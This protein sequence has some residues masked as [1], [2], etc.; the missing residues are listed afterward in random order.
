MEFIRVPYLLRV[1]DE[2]EIYKET[3]EKLKNSKEVL[4]HTLEILALWAVMT[5]L[6]KPL[7]KG[8]SPSLAKILDSLTPLE[9]A[10]LYENVEVPE[11]LSDEERREL[12]GHAETLVTEHQSLP[13]YEGLMG[14]SAR[15]LKVLLQLASTESSFPT[16]GPPALFQELSELI[17]KPQDYEYLR[18]EPNQGYHNYESMIEWARVAWLDH[19]ESEMLSCLNFDRETQIQEFLARYLTHVTHDVRKEKVR[20]RHTGKVEDP[21]H[22]LMSD[23]ESSIGISA[24]SL[25]DFRK[26]L[27]TRL[28]AWSIENPE[29]DPQKA[30]PYSVIFPDLLSKVRSRFRTEDESKIRALGAAILDVRAFDSALATSDQSTLPE[31]LRYA[32]TAYQGLQEKFGYGPLGAKESLTALVRARYS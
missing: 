3:L 13:F 8:K 14:A 1:S 23:F 30:L 7:F 2:K 10:L 16:L 20:N 4:P 15:E 32:I 29:R 24:E 22:T 31:G 18:I 9:K 19:V 6:K 28:G 11:R 17:Q 26:N 5:R 27:V 21:D 12:R 25:E